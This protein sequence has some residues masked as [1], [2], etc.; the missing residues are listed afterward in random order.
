MKHRQTH[1][2]HASFAI[3]AFMILGYTVKFYPENLAGIDSSIQNAVRGDLPSTLTNFFKFVTIIGNTSAQAAIATL[4][5]LLLWLKHYKSEALYVGGSAILAGLLIVG[6]KN[7]YQ[8]PRPAIT[9]LVYA[10]GFSFPSGHSLGVFVIFTALALVIGQR[11][12]NRNVRFMIYAA[13][14][15]LI[16][17]VG[18]SRIYLGVH[19]PTDVFAGFLLGYG[20]THLIYP[21]YD[22]IRF[23]WRFQ[24]KQK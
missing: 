7:L 3:L 9:H 19:H 6:L 16:F 12:I 2:I 22:R 24:S 17:L 11:I 20:L 21:T 23:E 8:R 4:A 13:A 5:V 10:G 18:L 14:A 1:Y 15:L